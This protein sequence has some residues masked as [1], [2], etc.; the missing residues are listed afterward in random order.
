MYTH[1][2]EWDICIVP[3]MRVY[4]SHTWACVNMCTFAYARVHTHTLTL[5]NS[6]KSPAMS[7]VQSPALISLVPAEFYFS[8][9]VTAGWSKM[10]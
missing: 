10:T 5:F 9:Q 6:P 7:A 4:K 2:P 3:E 8:S 1:S